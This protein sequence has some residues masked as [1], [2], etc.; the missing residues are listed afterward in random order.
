MQYSAEQIIAII[1][2]WDKETLVFFYR[3]VSTNLTISHRVIGE[4]KTLSDIEKLAEMTHLNE[5]HH[6]M[7]SW[8]N[9]GFDQVISE[10]SAGKLMGFLKFHADKMQ[11]RGAVEFPVASA[12]ETT[13]SKLAGENN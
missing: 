10:N 2:S 3:Q 7:L 1:D 12:F 8:L 5:F 6:K 13:K 11:R 4:D 9:D